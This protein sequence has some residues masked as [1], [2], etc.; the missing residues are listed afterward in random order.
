MLL[1][2]ACRALASLGVEETPVEV[3]LADIV[4]K[5]HRRISDAEYQS[6]PTQGDDEKTWRRS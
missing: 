4:R 1:R 3:V 2:P 6:L 5:N